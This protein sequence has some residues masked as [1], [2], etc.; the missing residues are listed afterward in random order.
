MCKVGDIILVSD[1]TSNGVQLGRHSF[2]V[3]S[4]ENGKIGSL[5]YDIV[6]SVLS[7]FKSEEHKQK[8]LKYPGNYLI[9]NT[10]TVTVPD[11]GK[12]GYLKV[13]QLFFFNKEKLSYTHIGYV[14]PEIMKSIFEYI[15]NMGIQPTLITDNL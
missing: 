2:V 12:S 13:D 9:E 11:N 3:V 7:S 14:K 10:D 1:Y 5:D 8:K 15:E 6:T 4:D